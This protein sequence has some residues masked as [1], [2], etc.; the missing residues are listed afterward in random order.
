MYS[1]APIYIPVSPHQHPYSISHDNKVHSSDNSSYYNNNSGSATK[2]QN[3]GVARILP[4]NASNEIVLPMSSPPYPPSFYHPYPIL[5]QATPNTTPADLREQA[6]KISHSAIEKRRRERINDKIIQLKELIPS[7]AAQENIH[8]MS[9]LQSAIDYI[10]YLKDIV[11]SLE[12][13][14]ETSKQLLKGEHLKVKPARSML[15]KEVEPFT[16]QF[17]VHSLSTELLISEAMTTETATASAAMIIP[18]TATINAQGNQVAQDDGYR[19]NIVPQY[20]RSDT[21]QLR[22][23]KPIDVIQSGTPLIIVSKAPLTPPH[24]PTE[25]DI[26]NKTKPNNNNSKP[27]EPKHMSLSNI[28]C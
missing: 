23:L 17:S 3:S 11:K 14:T 7:C 9:I 8:K 22:G 5:S 13:D 21:E 10:A 6:R 28:L 25:C 20:Q 24:E 4:K 18:R 15:P 16:T 1:Q 12:D 19:N 26:I 2:D 27:C